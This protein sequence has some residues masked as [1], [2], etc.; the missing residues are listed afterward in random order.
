MVGSNIS[1]R[2]NGRGRRLDRWRDLG[3]VEWREL[4]RL[5]GGW[6]SQEYNSGRRDTSRV[7][8]ETCGDAGRE[9]EKCSRNAS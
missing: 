8:Q 3:V 9:V 7:G 2:I 1:E 4:G 6:G 5:A